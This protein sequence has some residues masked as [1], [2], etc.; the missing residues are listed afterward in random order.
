MYR[1]DT[2]T[3]RMDRLDTVGEAPGWIYKHR[4]VAA[5]PHGIRIWDGKVVTRR[6]DT[7][8]HEQN[9]GSFVLDLE[10][11]RWRRETIRGTEHENPLS[12]S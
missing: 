9:F 4:A 10:D 2:R 8:S 1:L 11:L 5:P 6:D 3:L 12:P 7:E